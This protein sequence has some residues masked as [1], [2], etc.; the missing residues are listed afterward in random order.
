MLTKEIQTI[1]CKA[2]IQ[3]GN[4]VAENL[5]YLFAGEL[6]VASVNKS[7]YV[8]EFE[9]KVSRADFKADVK[10]AKWQYY[11]D[12]LYYGR[13]L[14]PNYFTYAC[15]DGLIKLDELSPWVGLIYIID[16]KP[17]V[18]RKP[19]FIHRHKIDIEKLLRKM[20]TVINCKQYLGAQKL[21]IKNREA[22]ASN[23]EEQKKILATT[24]SHI[25][26]RN[27]PMIAETI[28]NGEPR[29]LNEGEIIKVDNPKPC[30]PQCV[31]C[32][33]CEIK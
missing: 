26:Q 25:H 24:F 6:D 16:G 3:K 11:N 23:D 15:P 7:G 4:L 8:H 14:S 22:K 31:D 32:K 12:K 33:E 20:I 10:K 27:N 17:E 29:F 13:T 5:N 9:V 19:S 2:E 1:I 28:N 30:F 18:I 21:T